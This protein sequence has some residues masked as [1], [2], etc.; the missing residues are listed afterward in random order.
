MQI[1][2]LGLVVI[3]P[4]MHAILKLTKVIFELVSNGKWHRIHSWASTV[5]EGADFVQPVTRKLRN[6]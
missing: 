6:I 4:R 2:K 5:T 3:V 1:L